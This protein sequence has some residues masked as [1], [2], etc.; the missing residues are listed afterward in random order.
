MSSTA[1]AVSFPISGPLSTL[2]LRKLVGVAGFEPATQQ[3][4][5]SL[6]RGGREFPEPRPSDEVDGNAALWR[7][8]TSRFAC[9]GKPG[10]PGHQWVKA[11]YIDPAPLGNRI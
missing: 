11:R 9:D 10:G 8:C 1:N 6:C 2:V 3:L 7:G 4:H 5:A